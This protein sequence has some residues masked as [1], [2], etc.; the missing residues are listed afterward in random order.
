MTKNWIKISGITKTPVVSKRRRF[1]HKYGVITINGRPRVFGKL[2]KGEKR[3]PMTFRAWYGTVELVIPQSTLDQALTVDS[4]GR[5]THEGMGQIVW[6]SM[7]QL[8]KKPRH[9]LSKIKIRKMLP[10]LSDTQE[11]LLTAFLLHDFVHNERHRSK[12]YNEVDII[13]EEVCKLAKNHHNYNFGEREM[14]L[15]STLQYYDRLSAMISR[16][17][18]WSAYSR[19]R[20]DAQEEIDFEMLKREVESCQYSLCA[21]YCYVYKSYVLDKI[22]EALKYGFSSLKNHLLLMVNL[23]IDDFHR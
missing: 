19:Y 16:K 18:R 7:K 1:F 15:L 12:I 14:P 5:Y 20:V 4:I 23:Y 2:T 17:F 6:K 9:T 13:D 3:A 21:L 10:K 8:Q 11:N 22:N